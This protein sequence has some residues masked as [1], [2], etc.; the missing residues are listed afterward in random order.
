LEKSEP[1]VLGVIQAPTLENL[2][3]DE[4]VATLERVGV[5]MLIMETTRS[6]K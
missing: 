3:I 6:P 1:P 4:V 2:P 5:V